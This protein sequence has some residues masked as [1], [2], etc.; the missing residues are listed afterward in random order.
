M[1]S[2]TLACRAL[3]PCY[4]CLDRATP[5]ASSSWSERPDDTPRTAEPSRRSRRFAAT[6][7]AAPPTPT[8]TM[9]PRRKPTGGSLKLGADGRYTTVHSVEENE[10]FLSSSLDDHGPSTADDDGGDNDERGADADGDHG[11]LTAVVDGLAAK[12][13]KGKGA[14]GKGAKGKGAASSSASAGG[15]ADEKEARFEMLPASQ[16]AESEFSSGLSTSGATGALTMDSLVNPLLHHDKI[17]GVKSSL[18]TLAK[19]S[20]AIKPAPA[21][22]VEA[23]VARTSGE[24]GYMLHHHHRHRQSRCLRHHR[25]HRHHCHRSP[26]PTTSHHDQRTPTRARRW[27][28]GPSPSM[29]TATPRLWI[30]WIAGGSTNQAL[31]W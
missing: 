3:A 15:G 16:L 1:T 9:P 20:A 10:N 5:R 29:T 17:Q 14:K 26:P 8:P 12:G 22:V 6:I 13:K 19:A 30:W 4:T 7:V 23:R 11:S 2:N 24:P 27:V 25:R 21:A 31:A 28:N 18:K